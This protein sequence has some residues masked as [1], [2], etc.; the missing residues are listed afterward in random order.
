MKWNDEEKHEVLKDNSRLIDGLNLLK[1][2]EDYWNAYEE[3]KLQ[4][5]IQDER[6]Y[7]WRQ[8]PLDE[9]CLVDGWSQIIHYRKIF[10]ME[11]KRPSMDA[12]NEDGRYLMEKLCFVDWRN[13]FKEL[14]NLKSEERNFPRRIQNI[15]R[16]TSISEN[17]TI[18]YCSRPDDQSIIKTRYWHK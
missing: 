2:R 7:C 11:T 10:Q 1:I 9:L 16:L 5:S 15:W 17:K 18:F 6:K 4:T 14:L 3:K 12:A 8:V 13:H